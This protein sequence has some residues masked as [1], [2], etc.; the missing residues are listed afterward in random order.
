MDKASSQLR[1]FE[2]VVRY[3]YERVYR[4][5]YHLAGNE[6]TASDLTQDTFRSAWEKWEQFGG[7]S[8]VRTWLH[9][10]VYR[11]FLDF[12]RKTKSRTSTMQNLAVD[13]GHDTAEPESILVEVRLDLS[14][15]L[16][17]LEAPD[18][19][20]I[21]LRYFQGMSVAE[22]AAAT[23]QPAG[24]VKWRVHKALQQLRVLLKS[25]HE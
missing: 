22:T 16:Q 8:Q 21:V 19:A 11:K 10:I 2:V 7:R 20:V 14:Q 17:Q 1:E 9:S 4:F 12:V 25:S 6:H 13:Y 23:Q 3:E 5:A 15:A 18:K 24:T